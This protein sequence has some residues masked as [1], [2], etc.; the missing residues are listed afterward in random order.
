MQVGDKVVCADLQCMG[1]YIDVF[2]GCKVF[3]V[4]SIDIEC[5]HLSFE[6]LDGEWHTWRFVRQEDFNYFTK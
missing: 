4:K 5:E 2:K 1:E 6:E 3:T